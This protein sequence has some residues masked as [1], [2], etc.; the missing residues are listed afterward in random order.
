MREA[1]LFGGR[2][3][4]VLGS[5]AIFTLIFVTGCPQILPGD[6]SVLPPFD[7][8]IGSTDTGDMPETPNLPDDG[9]DPVDQPLPD[10]TVDEPGDPDPQ[11]LRGDF[12]ND[13]LIDRDDFDIFAAFF[14][15]ESGVSE[16]FRSDVD[17]DGDGIV[18]FEDY[19]IW[20]DLRDEAAAL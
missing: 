4:V 10:D 19:S 13:G 2:P 7:G 16:T 5:L 1:R 9:D 3:V 6:N 18:T 20:L 12:N 17:L 11:V 8:S 14:G 15:T